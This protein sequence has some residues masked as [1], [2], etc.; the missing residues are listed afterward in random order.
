MFIVRRGTAVCLIAAACAGLARADAPADAIKHS[1]L[2]TGQETYILD[3]DGK[4]VWRYPAGTR[5]GWVL[6]SGDLLLALSKSRE[7]PGGGAAEVT[8]DG[9]VVFTFK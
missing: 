3:G 6:P 4:V 8:R 5:D 9:E 2:A 7:V 1:F